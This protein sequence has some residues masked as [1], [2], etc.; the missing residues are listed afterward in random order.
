MAVKNI[1]DFSLSE[2]W[3]LNIW[4]YQ[5]RGVW[6]HTCTFSN[7]MPITLIIL[8]FEINSMA[9]EIYFIGRKVQSNCNFWLKRSKRPQSAEQF[10]LIAKKLR[11]FLQNSIRII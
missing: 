4:D 3:D 9:T 11:T 1:A 5:K 6:F 8:N 7:G 10:S 2:K